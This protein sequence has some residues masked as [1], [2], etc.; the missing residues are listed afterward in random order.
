[1]KVTEKTGEGEMIWIARRPPQA[2]K[3]K[4]TFSS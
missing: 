4:T 1:M 3:A 2:E